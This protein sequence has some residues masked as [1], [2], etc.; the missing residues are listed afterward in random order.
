MKRFVLSIG[1]L[2]LLPAIGA[3]C[4][5]AKPQADA[6]G[7]TEILRITVGKETFLS[8]QRYQN[9]SSLA[10]SRTGV[11]AAF[12]PKPGTGPRFYRTSG[13]GGL[14]WG[15][16]MAAPRLLE[17]GAESVALRDGGVLKFLTHDAAPKGEAEFHVSPMEGEFKDGWFT[18]HSMFAWFND[19][20]T[21]YEV[22]P[23]RVYMPDAVTSKQTQLGASFWPIFDKGKILQLADGD[24]LAPMYGLFKGDTNSR[25]VLSR[26]SDRGHTWRY[27]A[28]VALLP[29]D[30]NPELPGQYGGPSEPTIA[31]LPNGQMIC[32]LRTQYSHYP[33][34]YRPLYA[35]W[36]D[37]GGKTW[38][39]PTPTCPHLMNIWPTLAVLDNGVV[40]CQYGRPGFHVTFST[41]NGH[42]WHDRVSLSDLHEPLI[43]GQFDMIKAGPNRLLTIGSDAAG[44]KVWP[45][46]VERL[47]VSPAQTDL[48]GRVL[49]QAGQPIVGAKVELGPNRYTA[50]SWME[51]EE[52]DVWKAGRTLV[53][54]PVLAY[55]SILKE[56][57]HPVAETDARG[58]FELKGVKLIE[59]VL[60]VEADG[61]APQWRPIHVGPEPKT[62][63]Q[64]FR[65]KAGRS[66]RGRVVDEA[67]KPVGGA[68]VVLDR[69]HIHADSD[70]FFH[71][72][73]DAPLP[74]EVTVK[75]FKR[76]NGDYAVF[77]KKLSL[78]QIEQQPVVL[79]RAK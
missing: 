47:K 18:L 72:A 6:V 43:T 39:K 59:Y 73:V 31:L 61:Y 68:C 4:Y 62:H 42:T 27:Y 38:T 40:A 25:V 29:K 51:G 52:L 23:V 57:G 64:E 45:I 2:T 58:Q 54:P 67:G 20:F 13:D 1:V 76:Y 14:S 19:D 15:P 11:V 3:E 34:E 56:N 71:W 74:S 22:A 60:T 10:I 24:L 5:G 53:S 17:G 49:D 30:P 41:N 26:S 63:S 16:E 65:L 35:C 28:T 8:P 78:A 70:G 32:V 48:T 55:R 9:C 66:V 69:W 46:D 21:K 79:H 50:D 33:A 44:T 75:A 12:Y 36:S 7:Q 37:D 77:E